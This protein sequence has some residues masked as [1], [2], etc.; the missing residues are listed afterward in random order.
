M[1]FQM[2]PIVQDLDRISGLKYVILQNV[3]LPPSATTDATTPR[4]WTVNNLRSL[5][6][7]AALCRGAETET[8]TPLQNAGKSMHRARPP[9]AA[10]KRNFH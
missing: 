10:L 8:E 7:L 4:V 9:V 5:H 3:L 1:T 2:I 6:S